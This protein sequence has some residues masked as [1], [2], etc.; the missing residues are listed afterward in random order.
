MDEEEK[1]QV[2]SEAKP[3]VLTWKFQVWTKISAAVE[4]EDNL[5]DSEPHFI[6]SFEEVIDYVNQKSL[7][8]EKLVAGNQVLGAHPLHLQFRVQKLGL[9]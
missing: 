2:V 9:A 3:Q 8:L 7:C 5:A 4:F 1:K 6:G